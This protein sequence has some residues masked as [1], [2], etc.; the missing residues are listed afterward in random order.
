M[1]GLVLH[2]AKLATTLDDVT[3]RDLMRERVVMRMMN[4]TR[5]LPPAAGGDSIEATICIKQYCTILQM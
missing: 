2:L 1:S 5:A 4:L 3:Q